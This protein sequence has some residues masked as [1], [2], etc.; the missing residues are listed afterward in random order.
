MKQLKIMLGLPRSG[1]STYCEQ[2]KNHPNTVVVNSDQIRLALHGARY[3]RLAEPMVHAITKVVTRSLF[4]QE[5][6]VIVDET[7]TT[8]GSIRQWLEIDP[9]AEFIYIDTPLEVCK[10]RA[11]QSKHFDLVDKGVIDRMY[12]N[13]QE[14]VWYSRESL[15]E[16][17][18][19][20]SQKLVFRTID[21][22]RKEQA[23]CS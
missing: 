19:H 16:F 17:N 13:L 7:N 2:F 21:L 20:P 11:L 8:K 10:D 23:A 15:E 18:K 1:K 14:L 12:R 3:N 6:C 22:L 9:D 5:Y 4:N